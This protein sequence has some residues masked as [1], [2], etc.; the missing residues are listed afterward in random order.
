MRL[1]EVIAYQKQRLQNP[2]VW[3]PTAGLGLVVTLVSL[4]LM[5]QKMPEVSWFRLALSAGVGGFSM[6][7]LYVWLSPTPWL[8]TGNRATHAP[9]LRGVRNALLINSAFLLASSLV[10]VLLI[11]QPKLALNL[12]LMTGLVFS[13]V[14]LHAPAA[15]MLGYFIT[16]WERTRLVK[17]ETEK[18]LREA[19]WV[20][21]RG[22][23]SPHV[24]F[25]ALN[26]L[27][28][29]VR[30]DPIAA[31][32]SILDLA[33]LY[34]ALLDHGS[35]QWT[36]LR[37]ERRLVERYLSVESMRLGQRLETH[38]E[39]DE[40]AAEEL[41]PPFLIQPLVENAIKH[42]ISKNPSGGSLNIRLAGE[43][44]HLVV[45]VKNTGRPLP[46]LLGNG[47]G[48]GNLEARLYLAFG[49]E[50]KFRLRGDEQQTT[51]EIRI[52]W[53]ALRRKG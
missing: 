47:V 29:L 41:T 50:A 27:A 4:P 5:L 3:I 24:L 52:P 10:Q 2:V 48:V 23:L 22:Q 11:W 21:L 40:A 28:E 34:R 6:S 35:Q 8:W 44:E 9:F 42:G 14:I 30:V 36:P 16:L 46:L 17:E 49:E 33:D 25:N 43:P 39:W 37:E 15:A 32:Q 51:A 45:E 38:W 18:K 12:G 19:H 1:Q 13:S 7:A 53:T 26:G 20:L 31:E